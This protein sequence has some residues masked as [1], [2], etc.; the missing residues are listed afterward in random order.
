MLAVLLLMPQTLT[1]L[2]KMRDLML[3]MLIMV[4]TT[5]TSSALMPAM[6]LFMP[7]TLIFLVIIRVWV[8]MVPQILTS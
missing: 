3:V 1:S 5:L 2:A 4:L 7:T 6:P 8:I